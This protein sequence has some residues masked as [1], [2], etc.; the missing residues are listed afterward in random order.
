MD[1][2]TISIAA[3][4]GIACVLLVSAGLHAGR[5][6]MLLFVL[7]PFPVYAAALAWGT[8][9][10]IIAS[11]V[12]I[13]SA[14]ASISPAVAVVLGLVMS[15]PASL[16][17]HQANLAQPDENGTLVWYPL[18]R[19]F[20]NM[21]MVTTAGLIAMMLYVGYDN[22]RDQLMPVISP[23]IDEML[24][25]SPLLAEFPKDQVEAL[26]I[27]FFEFTPFIVST[28]WII[29][30]VF[31]AHLAALVCRASGLMPRPADDIARTISLPPIAVGILVVSFIIAFLFDG[32]PGYYTA[33]VL[34]VFLT[35]FS[36]VGLADIHLRARSGGGNI[37]LLVV[38]Y[39]LI[40]ML[41]FVLYFFAFGGIRRSLAT[42]KNHAQ[43]P[44]GP[45]QSND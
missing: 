13:I 40:F 37:M 26:K 23:M 45:T 39:I 2:K 35:A 34:G 33:P 30:H 19:L 29:V 31:N 9:A 25:G 12:V 16:I 44:A 22:S 7:A 43:P 17:G 11:L 21:C 1:L 18:D 15:L 5:S 41:Q 28:A 38:I 36:L 42:L 14:A 32:K 8:N 20:F 6:G 4:A 27:K 3:L 24:A 10:A